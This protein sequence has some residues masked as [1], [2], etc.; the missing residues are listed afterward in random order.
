MSDVNEILDGIAEAPETE[1]EM[2]ETLEAIFEGLAFA[3]VDEASSE[4]STDDFQDQLA[5]LA[6]CSVRSFRSAGLM[7][8]NRGVIVRMRNGS[9]FQIQV[10]RSD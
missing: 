1:R 6:G 5:A 3:R 8:D 10:I 7:T 2:E 9:E 4:V